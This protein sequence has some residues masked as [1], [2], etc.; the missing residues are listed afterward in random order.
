MT[1][2]S[3]SA[4]NRQT[5]MLL[6]ATPF[7]FVIF[8]STGHVF[9]KLGMPYSGPFTFL[10]LR[11]AIATSMLV[12]IAV[13][14]NAPWPRTFTEAGHII[15]AGLLVHGLYLAGVFVS[16]AE[17]VS[18]GTLALITG[19]QPLLTATLVGRF[20]G[21][22]VKPIQ[23]L[24]FVLGFGG[25]LLVVWQKVGIGEGSLAGMLFGA[26]A[27]AA[28]TVGTLYQKRF[29]ETMDLRSGTAIQQG[30]STLLLG[31]LAL[32]FEDRIIEWSADFIIAVGW[33]ALI[34]TIGAYNLLFWLLRRGEAARVASLFYLTPPTTALMG[35]A[36]FGETLGVLALGG[37]AVAIL[38][39]WLANR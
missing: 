20:L 12:L 19:L 16:I 30:A 34:L 28:I 39:F 38:G 14:V 10:G 7:V 24:G 1:G 27:V 31:L 8:W 22:T 35:W 15:V 4:T 33:L 6:A 37:M 29:C 5:Q 26:G 23:W 21:E 36:L 2:T 9:T 11:F 3:T 13:A 18:V 32:S 17:G 25:V